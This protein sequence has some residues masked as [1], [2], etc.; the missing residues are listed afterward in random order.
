M[1]LFLGYVIKFKSLIFD[2]ILIDEKS[3]L[4]YR[5]FYKRLMDSKPVRI[6]FNKI[7]RFIRVYHGN[8][9]LVL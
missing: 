6:R 1:L 7:D 2:N 4:V 5:I 3:I 9:Y 8:K